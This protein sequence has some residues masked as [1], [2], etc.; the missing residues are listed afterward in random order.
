MRI[1][2]TV[3]FAA[4]LSLAVAAGAASA[5]SGPPDVPGKVDPSRVAAGSYKVDPDHTQVVFTANHFGFSN[6][7]GMIGAVTGTM[8]LDP[9][10][11][12]AARL[13]IEL[14]LGSAITTSKALDE[15]LQKADFFETDKFPTATFRSTRIEVAGDRAEITGDLTLRG[16]TKPVVLAARFTGAGVNPMNKAATV[17][18]EATASVKRSEFGIKFAL[19]MVAD[20]VDLRIVA[21]FEKTE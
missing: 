16:V 18:F 9:K 2:F 10:Q 7:C 4:V 21:A 8:T 17:G 12:E 13:V 3:P 15:H 6:Y 20:R 19:P 14:P 5:Q 1:Q 11:P